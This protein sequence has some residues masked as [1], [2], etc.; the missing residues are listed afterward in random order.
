VVRAHVFRVPD[1]TPTNVT[2]VPAPVIPKTVNVSG[3][4]VRPAAV[5]VSEFIPT[6]VPRVHEPT[7]ARPLVFVDCVGSVMV[8]PPNVT[9]KTTTTPVTGLPT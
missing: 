2:G 4:A 7:V 5:A 9:A 6:T 8:P 1:D 3:D